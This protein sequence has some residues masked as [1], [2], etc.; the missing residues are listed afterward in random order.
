[1]GDCRLTS[2]SRGGRMDAIGTDLSDEHARTGTSRFLAAREIRVA[3]DCDHQAS[4]RISTQF[5]QCG[6]ERL[7]I[8]AH[9]PMESAVAELCPLCDSLGKETHSA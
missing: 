8:V 7:R 4:R 6:V 3:E 1:M 9:E 5:G 2:A